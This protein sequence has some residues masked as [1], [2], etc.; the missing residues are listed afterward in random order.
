MPGVRITPPSR[1]SLGRFSL[2]K[3]PVSRPRRR[4]TNNEE[5]QPDVL[6][7]P[8][9]NNSRS[10]LPPLWAASASVVNR[11]VHVNLSPRNGTSGNA[12]TGDRERRA[13]PEGLGLGAEGATMSLQLTRNLSLVGLVVIL[14][15][16]SGVQ[17]V[18]SP[19]PQSA[20]QAHRVSGKSWMLPEARFIKRLLYVSDD[21]PPQE[22]LVY[23]YNTGALVGKLS[24]N[25]YHPGG[26]CVDAKGDVWIADEYNNTLLEYAHGGTTVLRT[27]NLPG[28]SGCAVSPSGDLAVIDGGPSGFAQV[29]VW[30]NASGKPQAYSSSKCPYLLSP[31]YDDHGNL[32]VEA[33][34]GNSTYFS[35]WP[36]ELLAGSTQLI[37]PKFNGAL[38]LGGGAIWDGTHIVLTA[39]RARA[40]T[41]LLQ[42][43]IA[44]NGDLTVVGIT[45]LQGYVSMPFVVGDKNPPA[46]RIL[47]TVVVGSDG[48]KG[49][50]FWHYPTGGNSFQTF[51]SRDSGLSASSVSIAN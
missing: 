21:A 33:S 29:E 40:P 1:I 32:V 20:S 24:Y 34:D 36:C 15:G 47:G 27:L 16:C 9:P 39:S 12:L 14:A 48:G 22:V 11:F 26:Q 46:N 41:K 25:I 18:T 17:S 3:A 50:G 2:T 8:M 42:V 30:K 44:G 31:A 49:V 23:N 45:T 51:G 5:R 7:E 10:M 13:A 43:A 38:Y 28:A 6:Y 4:C 37:V 35:F 19:V